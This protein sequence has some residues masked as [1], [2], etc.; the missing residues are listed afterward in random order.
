[1]HHNERPMGWEWRGV[2]RLNSMVRNQRIEVMMMIMVMTMM[3]W[4]S[5]RAVIG[6]CHSM[7]ER[8][9]RE[10]RSEERGGIEEVE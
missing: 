7:R 2:R 9:K 5:L 6:C 8:G 3:M 4:M 10:G 1:M